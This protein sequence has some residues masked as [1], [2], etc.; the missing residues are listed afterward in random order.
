M[1]PSILTSHMHTKEAL[2]RVKLIP[3]CIINRYKTNNADGTCAVRRRSHDLVVWRQWAD[4]CGYAPSTSVSWFIRGF[5]AANGIKSARWS[6]KC[7]DG[8]HNITYK[9][10]FTRLCSVNPRFH[11]FYSDCPD[12]WVSE[13]WSRTCAHFTACL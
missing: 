11:Q 4:V 5:R 10:T 9:H 8:N 6:G 3:L 12:F 1:Q 13:S 2:K 7:V